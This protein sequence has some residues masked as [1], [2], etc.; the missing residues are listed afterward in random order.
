ME[1]VTYKAHRWKIHGPSWRV[2]ISQIKHTGVLGLVHI[3]T[4]FPE[5]LFLKFWVEKE[6]FKS[7]S[8]LE[9]PKKRISGTQV[10]QLI[11]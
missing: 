10:T 1:L 2:I 11:T 3:C 6:D 5:E 4:D 9:Y 7:A 8:N